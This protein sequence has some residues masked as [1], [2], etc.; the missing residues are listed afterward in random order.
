MKIDRPVNWYIWRKERLNKSL[1]LNK[2]TYAKVPYAQTKLLAW[3]DYLLANLCLMS[4][5]NKAKISLSADKLKVGLTSASSYGSVAVWSNYN[6]FTK[7]Y[8]YMGY[9]LVRTFRMGYSQLNYWCYSH[10]LPHLKQI[11]R[12]QQVRYYRLNRKL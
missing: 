4:L 11:K 12:L 2:Q 1:F 5:S 6:L 8:L 9:S 3:S 7:F 10:E